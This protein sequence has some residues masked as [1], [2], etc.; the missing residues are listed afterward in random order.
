MMIDSTGAASPR[1]LERQPGDAAAPG[2]SRSAAAVPAGAPTGTPPSLGQV[3]Q[4]VSA[5][6]QSQQAR[7]QGLEF[8]VDGDTQRTVVKVVDQATGE[9]LRQIPTPEALE[10]AKALEGNSTRGVLIQQTA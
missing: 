3:Q 7:S 5:L 1:P 2:A 9:V 10:I 4:A 6:N 8:S